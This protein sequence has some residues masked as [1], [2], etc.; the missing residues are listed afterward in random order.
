MTL[1]FQH[2]SS[3]I[4]IHQERLIVGQQHVKVKGLA[5][6]VWL[7]LAGQWEDPGFAPSL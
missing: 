1:V 2:I 5:A 3:P 6:H 7:H 4:S